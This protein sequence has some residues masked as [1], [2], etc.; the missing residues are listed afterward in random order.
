M[1]LLDMFISCD[2]VMCY[3]INNDVMFYF[4]C[5]YLV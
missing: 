3:V 1:N 5:V 2:V 4:L